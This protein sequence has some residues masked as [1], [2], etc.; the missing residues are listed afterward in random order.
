MLAVD[1]GHVDLR[2][3]RAAHFGEGVGDGAGAEE[4]GL[5]GVAEFF[6]EAEEGSYASGLHRELGF[7]DAVG[8]RIHLAGLFARA[9]V[10]A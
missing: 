4:G 2:A 3:D 10:C 1:V 8:L 7:G 6:L 9:E 5:R